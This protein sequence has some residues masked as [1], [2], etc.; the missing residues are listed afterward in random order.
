MTSI[1]ICNSN[2]GLIIKNPIKQKPVHEKFKG[3]ETD[4]VL[5]FWKLKTALGR[6]PCFEIRHMCTCISVILSS[7]FW[8]TI[9]PSF[10]PVHGISSW[11]K[12]GYRTIT[13]EL[14][15]NIDHMK[16][17]SH[18]SFLFLHSKY[19]VNRMPML[20]FISCKS[21]VWWLR[22]KRYYCAVTF[23]PFFTCWNPRVSYIKTLF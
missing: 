7:V 19:V 11:W 22:S 14:F 8:L 13:A 1:I 6:L 21:S 20:E 12:H 2:S 4:G 5:I 18:Y 17:C 9:I 10:T 16:C 3:S 23:L 15:F